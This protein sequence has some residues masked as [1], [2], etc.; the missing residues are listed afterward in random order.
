MPQIAVVIPIYRHSVLVT[1]AIESVLEQ[2]T[3]FNVHLVLINDGCPFSE[4]DATCFDYAI[5]YP[6]KIT[7]LHS[8]NAGLSSARNLGI[9]YVLK[10]L[11]TVEAIYFLDADNRLRRTALDKAM[12]LLIED[13]NCDW[14]Y[15]NIDMFGL[16][17]AGDFGGDYSL[18]IH[19]A[20]NICE[21]GSL[22]KRHVFEEGV[23]FDSGMKLGFEDWDFFL[24]AA[25]KKFR[26]KNL[27]DFGF[28]YRKRPESMLADSNR[29]Q[30]EIKGSFLRK[31]KELFSPKYLVNLEQIEAPR[32]AFY[33][34]DINQVVLTVDPDEVN[35]VITPD[36]LINM[37]WAAQTSRGKVL[38]PAFLIVTTQKALSFLRNSKILHWSLWRLENALN[39]RLIA[40]LTFSES[41]EDRYKI[42]EQ[43]DTKGA[44]LD[45]ILIM[46][47]PNCFSE[48]LKDK[49]TTWINSLIHEVPDMNVFNLMLFIPKKGN[50]SLLIKR[51][52]VFDFLSQIHNIKNSVFQNSTNYSW[53]WR[54]FG[55]AQKKLIHLIPRQF[56][57]GSA[58]YPK[59][60]S[61]SKHIGFLL[62]IV[63]FGGVEK[64]AL[65]IALNLKN[66][67]WIPHLVVLESNEAAFSSEWRE[68]FESISFL[69]DESQNFWSDDST[70][71]GTDILPWAINGDQN[72]ALSMLYWLDVAVNCHGAAINGLMGKL[73][74]HGVKTIASLHLSDLTKWNRPTGHTYLGLAFE[75]VYDVF[76]TCS[77]NLASWCYAMGVSQDK[78]I[79]VINAP[80]YQLR[81]SEIEPILENRACL[82]DKHKPIHALY[83]GRLDRQKGLFRLLDLIQQTKV[84]NL[85]VEW[86]IVGKCIVDNESSQIPQ[87]INSIVEPPALS[88]DELT[89]LYSWADVLIIASDYEG[90]PLTILE[91]MRLGVVVISTQVGAISEVITHESNGYL[92][93][94]KKFVNSAFEILNKLCNDRFELLRI[95]QAAS[96]NAK[97]HSWNKSI[98]GFVKYLN[99]NLNDDIIKY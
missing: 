34:S 88:P 24:T 67:G 26:G 58:A 29:D 76:L 9:E 28:R 74:R 51:S 72:K 25:S 86:R 10:N 14:I 22:V 80:S 95:S 48:I 18:L 12:T 63:E 78:I 82:S 69:S 75:H 7:Y 93:D 38:I 99:Q 45:S 94:V 89:E 57:N 41:S 21:A 30:A 32:Y 84:N 1:E 19:T 15:P 44:H 2:I 20:L 90:L 73:K 17:W 59:L 60:R 87:E 61:A 16:K 97:K 96:F 92:F 37:I 5:N 54:D 23:L 81:S 46:L 13:K 36:E 11:P 49:K 79:P 3:S 35:N 47:S 64:V 91:A 65:N 68:V 83:L 6:N 4:T 98:N 33:L 8:I 56:F 85:P 27:E 77:N 31:H 71:L 66:E 40:T 43:I 39:E 62:P 50:D 42:Y 55:I 70:Y 53:G 52:T